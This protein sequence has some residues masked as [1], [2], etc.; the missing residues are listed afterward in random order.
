M[1]FV[2]EPSKDVVDVRD[3][4]TTSICLGV[5]AAVP[6]R[7]GPRRRRPR[8]GRL[9]DE[10]PGDEAHAGIGFAIAP[11]SRLPVRFR[12]GLRHRRATS[13]NSSPAAHPAPPRRRD[14]RP[15]GRDRAGHPPDRAAHARPT[16]PTAPTA[17]APER[18]ARHDH[19]HATTPPAATE[20]PPRSPPCS[21]CRAGWPA[22][23][24][25]SPASTT[26]SP[27]SWLGLAA[28]AVL[29]V[30]R[31]VGGPLGAGTPRR[32][33]PTP[34]TAAHWR[35]AHAPHLLTAADRARLGIHPTRAARALM[36]GR[37]P[38]VGRHRLGP[39]HLAA[40]H[41]P[42]RP[43]GRRRLAVVPTR[44]VHPRRHRR[45]PGRAVDPA[46]ARPRMVPTRPPPPG[47]GPDEPPHPT[48]PRRRGLFGRPARPAVT[49]AAGPASRIESNDVDL[50][51]DRRPHN[52]R[53]LRLPTRRRRP[54]ASTPRHRPATDHV[55]PRP[56]LR[57]RRRRTNCSTPLAHLRP[58]APTTSPAAPP[59]TDRHAPSSSRAPPATGSPAGTSCNAHP[60]G[61]PTGTRPA[62]T[63]PPADSGSDGAGQPRRL[64]ETP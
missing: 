36:F 62:P 27:S 2:Q 34:S 5:T 44:L 64:P 21:R 9:A 14:E 24:L 53:T 51:R 52:A 22:P 20:K 19:H 50:M 40:H 61:P 1:A 46:P 43:R 37:W 25:S 58:A 39:A 7:H 48:T 3:L 47:G 13:P 31:A 42:P 56:A 4:F 12:A 57:R 32:R 38:D 35:A 30:G 33:A 23:D 10:I 26:P 41:R 45:R 16:A 59:R 28:L 54:N 8:Q 15:L 17:P 60:P 29:V 18:R 11:G 6:R 63:P 49:G 55:D